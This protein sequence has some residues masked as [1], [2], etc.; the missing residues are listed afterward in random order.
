MF[1]YSH[2]SQ[3][4]RVVAFENA[5]SNKNLFKVDDTRA[6]SS[7]NVWVSFDWLKKYFLKSVT[8]TVLIK[9]QV[10]NMKM[11]VAKSVFTFSL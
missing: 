10:F 8:E 6:T 2:F 4:L 11:A 9:L 1:K 7:V 5:P 3:F